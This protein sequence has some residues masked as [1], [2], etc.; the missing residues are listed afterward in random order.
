MGSQLPRSRPH[1]VWSPAQPTLFA[2]LFSL[3]QAIGDLAA[4]AARNQN[5][6]K[7]AAEYQDIMQQATKRA[8]TADNEVAFQ[9]LDCVPN[10]LDEPTY[11]I[12]RTT[13]YVLHFMYCILRTTF[14]VLHFTY[15]F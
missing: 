9:K 6:A 7:K 4:L 5:G 8:D 10:R 11:Y 12:L 13:F 1:A 14:Y 15:C 2:V 3:S